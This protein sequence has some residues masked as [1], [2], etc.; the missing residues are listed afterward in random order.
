M[1]SCDLCGQPCI[2]GWRLCEACKESARNNPDREPIRILDAL[3]K[4][5]HDG[6]EIREFDVEPI[7]EYI[8][9]TFGPKG[10]PQ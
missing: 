4:T 8:E 1:R 10:R 2:Y 5:G 9:L 7:D 3:P 6:Q